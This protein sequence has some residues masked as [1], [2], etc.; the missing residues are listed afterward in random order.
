[1]ITIPSATSYNY[2]PI[3]Y[4]FYYMSYV[5]HRMSNKESIAYVPEEFFETDRDDFEATVMTPEAHIL[6]K[7]SQ[8]RFHGCELCGSVP[9]NLKVGHTVYYAFFR[10]LTKGKDYVGPV[11][12]V[13][14]FCSEECIT[15]FMLSEKGHEIPPACKDIFLPF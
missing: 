6:K 2:S 12:F 3:E 14:T 11:H 9:Q 15:L 7:S 1:M 4:S 13:L 8:L 5:G 10:A